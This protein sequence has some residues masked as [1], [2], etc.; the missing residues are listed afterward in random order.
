[1][2]IHELRD[3]LFGQISDSIFFS[4]IIQS[5]LPNLDEGSKVIILES[6]LTTFIACIVLEPAGA[7][8]KIGWN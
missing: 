1:M 3:T 2:A 5:L 8:A 6:I 7:L 4:V